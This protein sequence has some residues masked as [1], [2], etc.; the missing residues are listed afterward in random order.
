MR[1]PPTAAAITGVPHAWAS[2]ATRPNDSEYEGT[3]TTVAARYQSASSALRARRL[4]P[5]QA[6]DAQV[7]RQPGQ[8][9]RVGPPGSARAA[10][11]RER[12]GPG[13]CRVVADQLGGGAQH[14]VGRLE[15]LHPARE[16]HDGPVGGQAE[17]RR[18]SAAGPGRKTDRSTPGLTVQTLAGSAPYS[19]T[20]WSASSSVLAT[21][22]S[23]VDTTSVSPRS[24]ISGSAASPRASAAFFTRPSVCMDC[25][26][27]TPQRC[28]ATSADLAGEP[29][30]RVHQ[31]VPAGGVGGL[32]AQHLERELAQL[33]GQVGLVQLLERAGRDVPDQHAGHQL[34]DGRRIAGHRPGEDLDLHA[35]AGQPL[36]DL[37]HVDIQAPGVAGA[38][39]FK[40]RGMDTDGR[41]P[42]GE[43]SRHGH[44]PPALINHLIPRRVPARRA[45][46]LVGYAGSGPGDA[47]GPGGPDRP[48]PPRRGP[49]G[50]AVMATLV[51]LRHGESN[52]TRRACSP[53]GWTWACPSRA[54]AR[55][56][57]AAGCCASRACAPD[58]VH[59]SVLTRAI[60]TANLALEA[61]GL[62]WL[63]VRRSW[64]LNERHYGA[65]QG[66]NKAQTRQ[67]F[68]DEQFMLW[69]RSYDV[70]P[71]PLA[72]DDP[73]S[74]AD[75][76]RYALLPPE[77]HAAHRVP[78]GRAAPADAVLV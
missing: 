9:V 62:L 61:A 17:P 11:E 23:A 43:A 29:V 63:P 26:S 64:R 37:D 8:A 46:C 28:R 57:A 78:Q 72:D 56:R 24:R 35:A 10:D 20:S 74:Q 58:V 48:R 73:L 75:D 68:G 34:G 65:L 53:A 47:A 6:G 36:G 12:Q 60:Q 71:P 51:L 44:A 22:R 27:G 33:G 52:G 31:V 15:R 55:R 4:Q 67:E 76:P 7:V 69:R 77:L 21:S 59:T 19:P 18:A 54:R 3:M 40:R 25:T 50:S 14:Q 66:K 39:L 32:R 5:D 49:I 13:Q 41:D 2:T 70:P 38:W 42:P 30:M 1:R 45:V 16:H